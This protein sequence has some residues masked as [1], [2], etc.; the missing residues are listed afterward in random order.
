MNV[1]GAPRGD[2]VQDE[3]YVAMEHMA[4]I[5]PYNPLHFLPSWRSDVRRDWFGF[6]PGQK[7]AARRASHSNLGR[8][9][10]I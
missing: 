5:V 3:R 10:A 6:S 4:G 2:Y 9:A 7:I 8:N 1:G